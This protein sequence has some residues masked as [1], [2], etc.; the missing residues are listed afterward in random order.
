[1]A[2][3]LTTE[4]FI[5]KAR[6]V[7]GDLY[8][9]DR[10]VYVRS[11]DKV[12]I[13]CPKH[14]DFNQ[15]VHNHLQGCGCAKCADT[16][17]T[18]EEFVEKARTVHGDKYSYDLAVYVANKKKVTITCPEHGDFSQTPYGHLKGSG[19]AKCA[20]TSLTTEEFI[21]KSREV[22]GDKY[23]YERTVYVTNKKKVVITC[24]EHGDFEQIPRHHLKGGGCAKCRYDADRLTTEEFVE[25][26]RAVHGSRYGYARTVYVGSKDK[27]TITCPKHGDFNQGVHNH[28]LGCGCPKCA[29]YGF[30]PDKQAYLY[31]LLDTETH[32][33]VKIGISNQPDT[34]LRDLKRETP[35][36][37]ERIDLFETPP[38]VTL[39]IESFC[40]SQLESAN[41]TG[42][43]GATEWFKFDGGKLEAL[44]EFILS[45]GGVS[46]G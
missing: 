8:G 31:I 39:Q 9:Y 40:H 44:R 7:H 41:L 1:M 12:I 17:L 32:S 35:F 4:E 26:A 5:E 16:A 2:R 24:P 27:I 43:D 13:T 30:N 14:G 23:S 18:T 45:M 22:H 15:G 11:A 36:A 38:T 3:R 33:R 46:V 28:L 21:E 34:R 6:A 29:S 37:L 20:D 19:C 42:F 10:A 25:K